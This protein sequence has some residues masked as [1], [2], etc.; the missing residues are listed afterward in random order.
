MVIAEDGTSSFP[1]MLLIIGIIVILA[2]IAGIAYAL[3][4]RRNKGNDGDTPALD[5]GP[6]PSH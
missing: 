2:V 4:R 3:T 5:A 1:T 6:S